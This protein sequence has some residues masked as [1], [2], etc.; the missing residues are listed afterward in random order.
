MVT[1]FQSPDLLESPVCKRHCTEGSKDYVEALDS[2]F[3]P[4]VILSLKSFAPQVHK[5]LQSHEGA[6]PLMRYQHLNA[7][8]IQLT[9]E[10]IWVYLSFEVFSFPACYTSEL[11]ELTI[12]QEGGVP[13]EHFIS[14]VPGVNVAVSKSGVKKVLWNENK[15]AIPIGKVTL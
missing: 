1:L 3:L 7:P 9:F 12:C 5:L 6:M 4:N 13:L 15:P 8:H 2:C 10:K 14:C 11:E